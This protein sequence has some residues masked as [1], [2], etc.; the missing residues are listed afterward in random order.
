MKIELRPDKT[1]DIALEKA[2]KVLKRKIMGDLKLV[3]DR[4]QGYVKPSAIRHQKHLDILHKRKLKR[5]NNKN[6]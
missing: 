5:K 4:H 6:G 3:R 2:L 1:P